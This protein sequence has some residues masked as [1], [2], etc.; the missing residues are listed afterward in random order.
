MAGAAQTR[1]LHGLKALA[2]RLA[3][4]ARQNQVKS[5]ARAAERIQA[6]DPSEEAQWL[7]VLRDTHELLDVCR[8]TQSM[9]LRQSLESV[10]ERV[11]A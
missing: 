3:K 5:I 2:H 8:A 6:A 9:F 11:N 7:Q 4:I 10:S 1:D